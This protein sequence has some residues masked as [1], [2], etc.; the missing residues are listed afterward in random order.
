MTISPFGWITGHVPAV[1]GPNLEAMHAAG[2]SYAD[3]LQVPIF[4]QFGSLGATAAINLSAT[5]NLWYVGNLTENVTIQVENG[6]A[7][8][9]TAYVALTQ[10]TSGTYSVTFLFSNA[11]GLAE[12]SYGSTFAQTVIQLTAPTD[13]SIFVR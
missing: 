11:E 1:N 2:G 10:T 7:Q 8:G 9:A 12:F 6:F 13:S 3:S 5:Q 4:T